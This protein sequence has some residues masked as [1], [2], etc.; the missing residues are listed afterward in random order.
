M[1]RSTKPLLAVTA[2]LV[3]A[4]ASKPPLPPSAIFAEPINAFFDADSA[5]LSAEARAAI[6]EAIPRAHEFDCGK[7]LVVGHTDGTGTENGNVALSRRRAEAV[8]DELV[9]DGY[10]GPIS[11]EGQGSRNPFKPNEAGQPEPINRR[12]QIE[13]ECR[14]Q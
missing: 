3:A 10:R 1:T 8:R 7:L 13:F 11:T 14:Y 9:R 2:L 12:A 6:H 5:S 4:C